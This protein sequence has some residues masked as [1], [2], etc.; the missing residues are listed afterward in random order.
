MEIIINEDVL[1]GIN[2]IIENFAS[3]MKDKTTDVTALMICL[4]TL[5]DLEEDLTKQFEEKKEI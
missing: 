3:S 2:D 1:K 5:I 4:Q